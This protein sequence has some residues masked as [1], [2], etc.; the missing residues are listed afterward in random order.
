MAK[1]F[2]F[3]PN[4]FEQLSRK[5]SICNAPDGSEGKKRSGMAC[6]NPSC[7]Q[8]CSCLRQ[9]FSLNG[10]PTPRLYLFI[11][12]QNA[13][14]ISTRAV[15]DSFSFQEDHLWPTFPETELVT[16]SQQASERRQLTFL[17]GNKSRHLVFDVLNN[18][19]DCCAFPNHVVDLYTLYQQRIH[20]RKMFPRGQPPQK[21]LPNC[22]CGW[23]TST[24]CVYLGSYLHSIS[25]K[26]LRRIYIFNPIP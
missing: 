22:C 13:G 5:Y 25:S 20:N 16:S 21:I 3:L 14:Q 10:G 24:G 26:I 1:V 15:Q 18:A 12:Y 17:V 9:L 7:F 11:F 8:Q 2:I 23:K 4:S 19:F 6:L